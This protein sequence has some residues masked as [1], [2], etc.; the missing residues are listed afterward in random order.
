MSVDVTATRIYTYTSY[1]RLQR[2]SE[3]TQLTIS[4]SFF[5]GAVIFSIASICL[6][7]I[8]LVR[9]LTF[10]SSD[11]VIVFLLCRGIFRISKPRS[12]IKGWGQS[13]RHM[14]VA[15]VIRLRLKGNLV[16]ESFNY[17]NPTANCKRLN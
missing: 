12:S 10:E 14:S 4:M 7:R 3:P 8:C 16:K 13:Q 1:C 9:V 2:Y 6:C 5:T 15:W 11:L 17:K